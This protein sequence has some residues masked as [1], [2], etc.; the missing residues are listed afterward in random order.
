M[1][2]IRSIALTVFTLF[3]L[4]ISSG[5]AETYFQ[6]SEKLQ[7]VY[8]SLNEKYNILVFPY[9]EYTDKDGKHSDT[10]FTQEDKYK[11]FVEIPT[12]LTSFDIYLPNYNPTV[13]SKG[14]GNPVKYIKFSFNRKACTFPFIP[15]KDIENETLHE[16]WN[17]QAEFF[18][19]TGIYT[20]DMQPISTLNPITH[21]LQITCFQCILTNI[22]DP[23][24]FDPQSRPIVSISNP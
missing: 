18:I 22:C 24:F 1:K 16:I 10:F 23:Q 9:V 12:G 6:L 5:H 8:S 20:I 21:L 11:I 3:V 4:H 14:Q 15:S 2:K 7:S 13:D 19:A 17:P